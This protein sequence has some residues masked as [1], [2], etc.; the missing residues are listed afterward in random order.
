MR[1]FKSILTVGIATTILAAASYTPALAG[2]SGGGGGGTFN[3]R[4]QNVPQYDPVIDY[5]RGVDA[6]NA[7]NYETAEIAFSK[8][9]RFY[10]PYKNRAGQT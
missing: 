4:S 2:G 8:V 3:G 5:Q 10:G 9:L 6:F 7:G 1:A